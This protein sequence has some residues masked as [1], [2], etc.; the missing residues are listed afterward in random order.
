MI[1]SLRLGEVFSSEHPS[2]AFPG[3]N[4]P[5]TITG[6][7]NL[8]SKR[9]GPCGRESTAARRGKLYLLGE[10]YELPISIDKNLLWIRRGTPS[11]LLYSF[12]LANS[13]DDLYQFETILRRFLILF[14]S[15]T[16]RIEFHYQLTDE[17]FDSSSRL[18]ASII[19]LLVWFIDP[20]GGEQFC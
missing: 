3:H 12:P 10:I 20:P 7:R 17:G 14:V 11:L 4:K 15:S 5:S 1:K 6:D 18:A 19:C 9:D 16:Y 13:H 2:I 8:Y